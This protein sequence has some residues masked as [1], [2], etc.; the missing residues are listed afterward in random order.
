MF[1]LSGTPHAKR[2]PFSDV[3]RLEGASWPVGPKGRDRTNGRK[4]HRE[5]SSRLEE[6]RL[7]AEL[8]NRGLPRPPVRG[9]EL[10]VT[11][12]V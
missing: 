4:L 5:I 11:R 12:G 8:A 9:G 7:Q 2:W 6:A 1:S 10:P 3:C